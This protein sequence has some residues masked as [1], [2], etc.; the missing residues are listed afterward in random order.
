MTMQLIKHDSSQMVFETPRNGS[1][2]RG[3]S[4]FGLVFA[5]IPLF[6][7]FIMVKNLGNISLGC[8]RQRWNQ[9]N[10][11]ITKSQFFGL[12]PGES[13][14]FEEVLS[15]KQILNT[16]TDSDGDRMVDHKVTISTKKEDITYGEAL[17]YVNGVRGDINES[18][19]VAN[20]INQF[21][22][23]KEMKLVASQNGGLS[24]NL[25]LML[26]LAVPFA[27][28]GFGII[29]GSSQNKT[30]ILDRNKSLVTYRYSSILGSKEKYL[31]LAD[32]N[33]VVVEDHKDS[34]DNCYFT[35]VIQL[36]SGEKFSLNT[37][38]H[39][40]QALIVVNQIRQFLYLP[41][42]T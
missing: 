36:T 16:S 15:A 29:Y 14:K 35:P 32:A 39:R 10:C 33:K 2:K 28:I 40:D 4:I 34:Y 37:L 38:G 11:Q 26:L 42:E 8:D 25:F 7:A 22:A 5:G 18:A 9:V 6:I 3:G 27:L 30:L 1:G 24:I 12:I 41:V 19:F 17:V 13:E 31:T 21:I 23:S 20:S